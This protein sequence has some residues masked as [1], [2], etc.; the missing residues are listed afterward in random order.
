MFQ[1]YVYVPES[2]LDAV[3]R[4]LFEA[5]AGRF[6]SYDRCSWQT[7]GT[8]QF[9]G[10][11]DAKPYIGSPGK[12]E[13]VKEIKLE[14]ICERVYVRSALRAMIDAHPYEEPAYGVIEISDLDDLT[15]DTG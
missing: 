4:A 10:T 3:K 1:I 12:T 5:G 7:E 6:A 2:H 13:V 11:L 15:D 8:G 14:L 9:R